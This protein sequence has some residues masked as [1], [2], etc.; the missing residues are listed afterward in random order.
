MR[1]KV[2]IIG[3]TGYAG[4]EVVRWLLGRAELTVYSSSRVG[5]RLAEAV[6]ALEGFTDEVFR[7]IDPKE[8]SGLDAVVLATPHGVARDLVRGIDAPVIVD[9]SRDHR[10][11]HGWAYGQVEWNRD[12]L[13]GAPRIAVPGCFATAISLSLAPLVAAGVARGPFHV[14]AMTGSTGSG[15]TASAGTHHPLRFANTRA[16]KVLTH[17]H[18]PEIEAFLA[19]LGGSHRVQFVPLSGPVDRGIFATSFADVGRADA[20][21][22]FRRA[23]GDAPYVRLREGTPELRHVRGT[24]LAD[25]TVYQEAETAVVL[26]AIDNLGKGAAGQAV[27]CLE[28]ALGLEP[29]TRRPSWTP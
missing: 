26:A 9:L 14:T 4:S 16:Y 23:Y 20:F 13:V 8:L 10:H 18:V 22:L 7:P 11:V 17:Q 21:D 5:E 27:Q 2:G 15:A 12:Q 19:T 3:A 25:L 1:P 6:P 29:E 24:A 28:L